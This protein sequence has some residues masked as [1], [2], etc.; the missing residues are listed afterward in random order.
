[1]TSKSIYGCAPAI[2]ADG[3]YH[4]VYRITNLA[5]NKHYYGCRTSSIDPYLDLG[6]KYFSSAKTN[7]WIIEDQ[8]KNRQ[9]YKYKIL[10]CHRTR[11]L[12]LQEEIKLHNRFNVKQNSKFYN[13]SNQTSNGFDTTGFVPVTDGTLRFAV[14]KTDPRLLSGELKSTQ[15][16]MVHV[17][18]KNGVSLTVSIDD[19]KYL[20][21]QYE[22]MMKGRVSVKDKEGNF[23]SVDKQD[24]RY[25]SGELVSSATGIVNVYDRNGNRFSVDRNDPRYLSGEL[26]AISKGEIVVRDK[27][28]VAF[29]VKNDDPRFISGELV[30][31]TKGSKL[32]E[33]TKQKMSLAHKGK[34]KSQEHLKK[35]GAARKG[36]VKAIDISS[37][38]RL[39]VDPLD[40]RFASGAIILGW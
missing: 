29:R 35:I 1:M 36:K 32:K 11:K 30:H 39:F 40:D 27:N 3:R 6:T 22:P 20:A 18:D 25:L 12:A 5:E 10:S 37:G 34:Q 38:K 31:V 16:G 8:K 2:G 17:R 14:M 13:V 23:Y 7:K 19:P 26:T 28:G 9:N 24:P 33:E 4:Y 21:G 15:T